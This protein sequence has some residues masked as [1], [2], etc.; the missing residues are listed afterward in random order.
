M[1]I[2]RYQG[3]YTIV[4]MSKTLKVKK[5]HMKWKEINNYQL[6]GKVLDPRKL[7]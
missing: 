5:V 2:E 1:K 3:L 7:V 6:C 4:R